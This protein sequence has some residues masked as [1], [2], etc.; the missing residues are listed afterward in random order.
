MNFLDISF[1]PILRRRSPG[2]DQVSRGDI[3][4]GDVDERPP[5]HSA[6][7]SELAAL[8]YETGH[9]GVR[10]HSSLKVLSLGY[11][12]AQFGVRSAQFGVRDRSVWGTESLSLGYE[13]AQ[14][15]VRNRSGSKVLSLG[16]ET[17]Q[18]GVRNPSIRGATRAWPL[19]GTE[20][21]T[22]GYGELLLRCRPA[23]H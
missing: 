3:E 4:A 23:S 2:V 7:V 12:S 9:F 6:R 1:G 19:W 5:G 14:F 8:G 13:S 20:L 15:G 10:I 21:A 17:G 11:E 22:L 16:Y 18:F